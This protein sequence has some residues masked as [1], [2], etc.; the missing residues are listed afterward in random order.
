MCCLSM[1]TV[2]AYE[3]PVETTLSR[4][5]RRDGRI[6]TEEPVTFN[7]WNDKIIVDN[8]GNTYE[9][10]NQEKGIMQSTTMYLI[11]LENMRNI[12][13]AVV[14]LICM[15]LINVQNVVI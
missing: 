3:A 13:T 12:L 9:I 14:Q 5:K 10:G 8:E 15:K 2:F 11:H 7:S 1:N 4:D 6:L